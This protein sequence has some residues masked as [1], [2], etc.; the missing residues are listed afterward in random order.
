[1]KFTP[2]SYS[3]LSVFEHC[4]YKFKLNY[5]D[6]ISIFNNSK[7]LEKGSRVHQIIELFEPSKHFKLPLFNYELLTEEEQK[8]CETLALNFCNSELGKSYLS[9]NGALGHEIHMG[10]S[11]TLGIANYHLD[12][13]L[14]RGKIDF[15]IKDGNKLK[16]I[17]W[18]TGKVPDQYYMKNDQV[19]LYAIW[20]FNMFSDV[21]EIEAEYVYVEHNEKYTFKFTREFYKNYTSHYAKKIKD[22][23]TEV[24]Y[25]KTISKLCDYC[26]YK[27]IHCF[28]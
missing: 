26:D 1:M 25:S 11:K 13:T 10:L 3:K 4:K 5:V 16:I 12:G 17:D 6:K 9:H 15:L 21:N 24:E 20:G 7:A 14:L 27:D 28:I 2:Y 22:C 8:D 23:E 18:K 19:M